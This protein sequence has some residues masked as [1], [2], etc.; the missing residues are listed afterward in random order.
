MKYL[1]ILVIVVAAICAL[2]G[3][4]SDESTTSSKGAAV[5]GEVKSADEARVQPGM[6]SGGPNASVKW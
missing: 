2:N 3:C 1:P 4:A 5:P 6:G